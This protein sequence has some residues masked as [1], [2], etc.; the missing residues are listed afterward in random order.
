MPRPVRVE[1]E[2]AVYH[3]TARGNERRAVDRFGLLLH[4]Y[5]LMPNHY[6]LL[7]QTPR[8]NLS[9]SMGWVQTTYTSRF[10]RRHKRVGHLYQ[11]RYKAHLVEEDAY[12][13]KL[14]LYVHLNP[15]RPRDKRKIIP[16]DRRAELRRYRWSSH[17]VYAGQSRGPDWLCLDWLGYFG[18]T[19]REAK[20]QY[21][22]EIG[23]C[24]GERLRNPFD[25]LRGGLVLGGEVFW[26]KVSSDSRGT[27]S[28]MIED[29]AGMLTARTVPLKT[30][31]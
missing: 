5:C 27:I 18:R 29:R 1:Y 24:F 19:R 8:A 21:N 7:V 25:D 16:S 31:K 14:I 28:G 3:V 12:A 15:V 2:N 17:R 20:R 22:K 9:Q 6:H 26:E 23:A 4:C 10:N 13:G 11:G 30:P